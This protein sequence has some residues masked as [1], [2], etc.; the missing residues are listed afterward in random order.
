MFPILFETIQ[1]DAIISFPMFG[2]FS[3]NPPAY[4]T[5]FGKNIY[6]YGVI[7]ALGF[8]LGTL[9]CAHNAKR[10]GLKSDDIYDFMLWTIPCSI[11]G[12]RLY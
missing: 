4:F 8:I 6:F 5:L 1:R 3:I 7:I 10:F 9:Y 2:D 12:A 11:I